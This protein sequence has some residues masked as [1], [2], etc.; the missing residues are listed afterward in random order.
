MS[1]RSYE[2]SLSAED[3]PD[4]AQAASQQPAQDIIP[5][6]VDWSRNLLPDGYESQ[7]P[8]SPT[9]A[10]NTVHSRAIKLLPENGRKSRFKARIHTLQHKACCAKLIAVSA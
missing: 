7:E 2:S 4:S 8:D 1:E 10:C 5:E 9:P 3:H 6:A